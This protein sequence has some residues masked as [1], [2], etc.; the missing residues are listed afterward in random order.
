MPRYAEELAK[1]HDDDGQRTVHVSSRYDSRNVL[2]DALDAD[3]A[4]KTL[5]PFY[6]TIPKE[7][8]GEI[9]EL[10]GQ[11]ATYIPPD[12]PTAPLKGGW[13][14]RQATI[15]P[16]LDGDGAAQASRELIT[17]VDD[18]S[19]FPPP[20]SARRQDR[21]P[22]SPRP[23]DKPARC[24]TPPPAAS[25]P[26]IASG[27]TQKSPISRRFPRFRCVS[28]PAML[29]IHDL[30]DRKIDL[31]RGNYFLKSSLTFQAMTRKPDWYKFA[32]TR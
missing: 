19:G 15:N 12:H 6:A 16:P 17:L 24:P 5:M 3:R 23:S 8:V 31:S 22:S 28:I 18:L 30:L 1:S 21:R 26:K 10:K 32:T 20:Y 25:N 29:R 11:Q 14:V 7:I 27:P 13:L 2:L 4:T 9:E